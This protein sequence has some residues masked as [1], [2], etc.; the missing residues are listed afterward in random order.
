MYKKTKNFLNF[1]IND[2]KSKINDYYI[3][4]TLW[5]NNFI[6]SATYWLSK[7]NIHL[8]TT[9]QA[10]SLVAVTSYNKNDGKAYNVITTRTKTLTLISQIAT[11][12]SLM[13]MDH[14]RRV[15]DDRVKAVDKTYRLEVTRLF[16]KDRLNLRTL[17]CLV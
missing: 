9:K 13:M 16:R 12:S 17:M 8:K 10:Y 6:L 7:W 11:V 1:N 14:R 3:H 15:V 4:T 2:N 5:N